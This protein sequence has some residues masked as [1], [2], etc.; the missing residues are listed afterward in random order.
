MTGLTSP[1]DQEKLIATKVAV[2]SRHVERLAARLAKS[3]HGFR[4]EIC[5]RG[6][7]DMTCSFTVHEGPIV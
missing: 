2:M 1:Q 6:A 4:I 3:N 5:G 7:S